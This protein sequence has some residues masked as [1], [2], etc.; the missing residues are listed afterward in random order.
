MQWL[1]KGRQ[2]CTLK[3]TDLFQ[4]LPLEI[5]N[6]GTLDLNYFYY[7]LIFVAYQSPSLPVV[8]CILIYQFDLHDLHVLDCMHVMVSSVRKNH[9]TTYIKCD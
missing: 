7:T 8:F 2:V 3:E 9:T 5:N 6:Q 4:S 1:A